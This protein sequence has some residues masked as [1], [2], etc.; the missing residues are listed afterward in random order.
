[1]GKDYYLAAIPE[2]F[3]ILGVRLLPFSPGKILLLHRTENV[4]A[5]GGAV[6]EEHLATAVW[7]CAFPFRVA[8]ASLDDP[9]TPAEMKKWRR[10]LGRVDWKEAK[11]LFERYVKEGSTF[12][13]YNPKGN[14][15][16]G[17]LQVPTVQI[18]RCTLKRWDESFWDDPWGQLLWDF[19][20]V[21]GIEGAVDICEQSSVENAQAVA[22]KVQAIFAAKNKEANAGT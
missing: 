19:F 17:I 7:L 13:R 8:L 9:K 10:K 18:V 2:P 12:P 1:M 6:T 15:G 16:D 21:K 5:D 14:P 11:A 4:F 3:T 20:T 22:D